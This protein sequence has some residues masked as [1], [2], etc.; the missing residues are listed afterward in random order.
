MNTI[1]KIN[2]VKLLFDILLIC[3]V[4][5][6]SNYQLNAQANQL[7][8][9]VGFYDPSID[10]GDITASQ[11]TMKLWI[12]M[13]KKQSKHKSIAN[14]NIVTE[15]YKN[16]NELF[17]ELQNNQIDFISLTVWDYYKFNLGTKVVPMVTSSLNINTKYERYYLVAHKNSNLTGI[18]DVAKMEVQLPNTN[19]I[20]LIKN[21]MEVESINKLG[22]SKA[23]SLKILETKQTEIQILL[24]M[25]FNKSGLAVIREGLFLTA[26]EMNPQLR[27]SIVILEESPKFINYFLAQRKGVDPTIHS[28]IVKESIKLPDTV[29]GRQILNIMKTEKV[30]KVIESD[31]Y[32][33]K[34]LFNSHNSISN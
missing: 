19:S 10:D 31:F 2:Y 22:K 28:E 34:S 12:D 1:N 7:T 25:F 8:L 20:E 9:K 27:Q 6:I 30:F 24:K 21:W 18:Q 32:E 3:I 17:S 26:C 11:E 29:E 16:K 33:V 15:F 14:A 4:L 23:S 5:A 13:V